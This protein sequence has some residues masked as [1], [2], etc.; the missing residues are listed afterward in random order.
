M[1]RPFTDRPEVTEALVVTVSDE[2]GINSLCLIGF[3]FRALSTH[4][5]LS[6]E[7]PGQPNRQPAFRMRTQKRLEKISTAINL[8]GLALGFSV[9]GL[10]DPGFKAGD[11]FPL[12]SD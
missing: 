1:M 6:S 8:L 10:L 9:L 4:W 12:W 2:L 5:S 7:P 3:L 11:S